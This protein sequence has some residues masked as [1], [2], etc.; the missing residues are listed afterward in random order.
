MKSGTQAVIIRDV[1]AGGKIAVAVDY[2]KDAKAL[3]RDIFNS[4]ASLKVLRIERKK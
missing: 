2:Q 1:S 4:Y 3:E